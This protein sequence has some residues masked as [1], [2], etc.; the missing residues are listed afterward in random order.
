MP[1]LN[2]DRLS[3]DIAASELLLN[4]GGNRQATVLIKDVLGANGV[5][6]VIDTVLD[7]ADS[8]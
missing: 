3:L 8:P 4:L 5:I 7:P 2:G 1:M 6:H